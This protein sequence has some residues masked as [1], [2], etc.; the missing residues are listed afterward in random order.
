MKVTNSKQKRLIQKVGRLK[1]DRTYSSW[2]KLSSSFFL[3]DIFLFITKAGD[4]LV[5][6]IITNVVKCELVKN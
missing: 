5:S 6:A 2:Q 1:I 3:V 4:Y